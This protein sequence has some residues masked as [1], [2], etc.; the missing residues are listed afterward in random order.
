[1]K[2]KYSI[3]VVIP[4]YN[5]IRFLE[6]AVCYIDSFLAE[7]FHDY[8]IIL[9][10]SGSTDGSGEAC[11]ELAAKLPSLR[12][13][14][15]G[16]RNGFGSA[17]RLGYK[18][19]TKDLV[20]LI[21]VDLPFPLDSILRALPLLSRYDCVLSYRSKDNRKL[22][23]KFQSIVYNTLVKTTLGLSVKHVNSAFK[24]FKRPII[25]GMT[26]TSNG[27]FIDAEV[28]YT[29]KKNNISYIEIPIELIDRKSGASSI[30]FS[31][32]LY[33]IKELAYF[34]KEKGK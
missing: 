25:Q 15:E 34:L 14:H 23:R 29:I 32:P 19:A 3:S 21:T 8:E 12:L 24:V 6:S 17:L 13:I 20:W 2:D 7:H 31:A 5:E 33:L 22:F 28:L 1:M 11:D 9:I 4:V 10:E 26:L 18:N 16:S 27:W 30:K